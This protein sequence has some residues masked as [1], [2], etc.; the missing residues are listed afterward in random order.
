MTDAT[1]SR[2][3][4][5]DQY[6]DG[7]RLAARQAVWRFTTGPTLLDAVLN[8]AEL[9]GSETV[10]DIGC[11]NG[12][13]LAGL[14]Q[15]GHSGAVIGLDLSE[16]MAREARAY[17]STAVADAQRLPLRTDSVDVVLCLH[18]LY[19]VPDIPR[20]AA[21][22]RRV[23]RPGGVILVATNDT[24]HAGEIRSILTTAVRAVTGTDADVGRWA[25]RFNTQTA[26]S[27]LS[28]AFGEVRVHEHTGSSPVPDPAA[29]RACVA[30]WPPEAV[31]LR[32]G[33]TWDAVLAEADLLIGA[34]FA[35]HP[36]FVITSRAAVL[37][38]A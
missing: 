2:Q 36:T 34:H 4:L 32:A 28:D 16:G 25:T 31:G 8:L 17:A 13:Y 37:V 38:C 30:S 12:R 27:L 1:T 20:A 23:T 26:Q 15:R 22:L 21:E 5:K 14:R 24:E 11:G 3:V 35:D 18:M 7:E 29:V 10:A 19:H 9:S 33:P 6:S